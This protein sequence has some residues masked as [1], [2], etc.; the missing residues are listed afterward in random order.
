MID[1]DTLGGDSSHANAVNPA[2][3]V[4]GRSTTAAFAT[5]AFSWTRGGGMIDLGAPGGIYSEA[6]AVNTGGQVM[7]RALR[8]TSARVARWW[9]SVRSRAATIM[10]SHGRRR[11]GWSTL[12]PSAALLALRGR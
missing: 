6:T 12:A 4:V 3:Q 10:R 11:Q 9:A 8:W 5:H 7:G 2:G 1:L